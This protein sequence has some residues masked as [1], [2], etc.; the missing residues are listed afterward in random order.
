[1]YTDDDYVTPNYTQEEEYQ[2][3]LK[4]LHQLDEKKPEGKQMTNIKLTE[5]VT[6]LYEIARQVMKADPELAEEIML[7]AEKLNKM[8]PLLDGDLAEIKRA[9]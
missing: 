9:T 5:S 3:W 6:T 7:C 1:M 4:D 2:Q 8:K